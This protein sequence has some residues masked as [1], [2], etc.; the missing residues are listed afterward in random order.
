VKEWVLSDVGLSFQLSDWTLWRPSL[1]LQSRQY[2]LADAPPPTA[3]PSPP[4][5]ALQ[6]GS[7]GFMLRAL[8]VEG[9]VP[10]IARVGDFVRY[11]PL[12]YRHCYIDMAGDFDAYRQKFSSKTRSTIVR[13]VRRFA[14]HCGGELRWVCYRTPAE[15]EIFFPLARQVSSKTYQERLLDAG[16]PDDSAYRA[17]M[18]SEAAADRVRAFLL[19]DGDRPVSYLFCPVKDKVL[20]YAY[21]GYDPDYQ[22]FSVGTVLQW[23][24]LEQLF[25]EGQ[26]LHFDFTE[27]Q[28]DHKRLFAT[29]ERLCANV[30]FVSNHHWRAAFLIRSHR[31]FARL[32]ANLG[33]L[34]ERWGLKARVRRL[35]RSSG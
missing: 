18:L 16:L 7:A 6:S 1:R 4:Q 22:K 34:L 23:L 32:G 35:L 25:G 30:M 2:G 8:P 29:H 12:Q 17:R 10:E 14:E 9:V 11:V 15:L 19:F 31:A 3:D 21:L 24:A 20:L 5:E 13:K 27:G 26:F 33:L 28:S